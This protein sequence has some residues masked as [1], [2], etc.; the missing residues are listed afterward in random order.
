VGNHSADQR[1]QLLKQGKAIPDPN[2]GPPRFPIA[3]ASDLDSAVHL[4]RTPEE[5]RFVYKR[6]QQMNM[7]GKIPSNWKSDGTLRDDSSS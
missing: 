6:A 5:R 4:A 1:R 2:G 7:L 3:D